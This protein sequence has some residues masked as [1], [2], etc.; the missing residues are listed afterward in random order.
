MSNMLVIG[1][2]VLVALFVLARLVKKGS[3]RQYGESKQAFE[4]RLRKT[5]AKTRAHTL[6]AGVSEQMLPI[7]ASIR[8]LLEFAGNPPGFSLPEEGRIVRLGTPAGE[9][10]I[11]YGV[12]SHSQTTQTRKPGRPQGSWRIS[13]PGTERQ[14]YME[15]VDAVMHLKRVICRS[16]AA[17][18]A[19]S[20]S[21]G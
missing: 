19:P 14:E 2:F 9:I 3:R 13:G 7:A 10:R 18:D 17:G 11:E 6:S 21:Q 16:D 1:A 5:D 8:E 20:A 12:Y 4:E 15:L